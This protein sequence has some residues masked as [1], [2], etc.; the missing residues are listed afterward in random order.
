MSD[1]RWDEVRRLYPRLIEVPAG[2]RDAF[3]GEMC[4]DD[5]E[6]RDELLRLLAADESDETFLTPPDRDEVARTFETDE[7]PRIAPGTRVGRYELVREI[8]V[9][10]MGV[11]YEA[12]QEKPRRRVALKVVRGELFDPERM[13]RIELESQALALLHHPGIVPLFDSGRTDDG[14]PYFAMEFVDGKS[15]DDFIDD[16]DLPMRDRLALFLEICSAIAYAHQKGVIHRDL[17]P[18]NILVTDDAGAG[19]HTSSGSTGSSRLRRAR[20]LDFG[21]AR[22]TDADVS[23]VSLP[24]E[25]G[26]ILG[27]LA[28]MSPE[29]ASGQSAD[30]DQ[31][32]DVY[33]LGVI[34]YEL[35]SGERPYDLAGCWLGEAVTRIKTREPRPLRRVLGRR[36]GDLETIVGK[37]LEKDPDRRYVGAAA[38]AEDVARY[39]DGLPV[40][41]HPPSAA[42]QLRK[43]V[44]RHKLVSAVLAAAILLG[45]AFLLHLSRMLG[46]VEGQR[47]A[48]A[49]ALAFQTAILASIDPAVDGRDVRL[50]D[51]IRDADRRFEERAF[52]RPEVEAVVRGTLGRSYHAL[53]EHGPA[54]R[55][56]EEALRL[57]RERHGE[58]HAEAV[59]AALYLG[60]LR[61]S[62]GRLDEAESLLRFAHA[63]R[64][65]AHGESDERTL[66]AAIHVGWLL[67]DRGRIAEA[68]RLCRDALD[69]ARRV[70]GRDE[71][72]TL[73]AMKNLAAILH[74]TGELEEAEEL[75]R[76]VLDARRRRHGEEH[77]DTLAAMGNLAGFMQWRERSAAEALL[78]RLLEIHAR[79]HGPRHAS[80]LTVTINLASCLYLQRE[81]DEAR[82]LCESALEVLPE[83]LG[84]E[85]PLTLNARSNLAAIHHA[86]GRPDEAEALYREA[87]GGLRATV[88]VEH[89]QALAVLFGLASLLQWQQR[90]AEAAEIYAVGAEVV[91]R[92][93]PAANDAFSWRFPEQLAR[94]L[95]D[96]ERHEDAELVLL[97]LHRRLEA[98]GKD[99][100]AA[101][102]AQALI[103]LYQSWGR[104][105]DVQAWQLRLLPPP[106]PP[107]D[108]LPQNG[109]HA[110]G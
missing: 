97:E 59:D 15:L 34:L 64:R 9:G 24:T 2:E 33:S 41:A 96:L 18:S 13:K 79:V 61:Q 73:A 46:L 95:V 16:A 63:A 80:T 20:V 42:Y 35:V 71:V 66:E 93:Y 91:P 39:L 11:V 48:K 86:S 12:I 7:A 26:R 62:Q 60:L 1:T 8:G 76:A 45:V 107:T 72:T 49:E 106:S 54:E 81:F 85:H 99:E 10:G 77:P 103:D 94:C 32:S 37:A 44:S 50:V 69:V 109:T 78:R 100:Q 68:E 89:P 23:Q 102:T 21:L 56:L 19:E 82:S 51:V 4:G 105:D 22:I 52:E 98:N 36:V 101:A 17:K 70:L 25:T 6:L 31:R 90:T 65:E 47:S 29:Q 27:T 43:L 110:K 30:I 87:L 14:S 55:H 75:Y 40:L 58:S 88:G 38:L 104:P 92:V 53:G 108:G 84:N 74:E 5:Q 28:Y 3:L 83:V 57:L 67:Q